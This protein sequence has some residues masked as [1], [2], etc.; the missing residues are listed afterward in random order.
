[1]R[2]IG[3]LAV[4]L[5]VLSGGGRPARAQ[6]VIDNT[7]QYEVLGFG[8]AN[9]VFTAVDVTRPLLGKEPSRAYG[10]VELVTATAEIAVFAARAGS[11]RY[12]SNKPNY[13]RWMTWAGVLGVHGLASLLHPTRP[14]ASDRPPAAEPRMAWLDLGPALVDSGGERGG[15]GLALSGRF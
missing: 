15:P 7:G 5:C 6:P 1:M 11:P 12:A 10:A 8:I 2:R 4:V 9:L 14:A 13:F 3:L